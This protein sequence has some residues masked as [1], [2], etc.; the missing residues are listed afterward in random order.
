MS[1]VGFDYDGYLKEVPEEVK[2]QFA[3]TH[4]AAALIKQLNIHFDVV[5][6]ELTEIRQKIFD[7]ND[8][9]KIELNKLKQ[10]L[11]YDQNGEEH[12]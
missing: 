12:A 2:A 8:I 9:H 5:D 1:I 11:E 10:M 7:A 3:V 6:K 4:K